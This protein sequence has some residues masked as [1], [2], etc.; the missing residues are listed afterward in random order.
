[1]GQTSTYVATSTF[2]QST[3]L[4]L[5]STRRTLTSRG[6]GSSWVAMAVI[7][8]IWLAAGRDNWMVVVTAIRLAGNW[9]VITTIRLAWDSTAIHRRCWATAVVTTITAILT[10]EVR[11]SWAW[12]WTTV[13]A[14]RGAVREWRERWERARRAG[15]DVWVA[16]VRC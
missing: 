7:T 9:L 14:G 4:C 12:A 11:R 10:T 2:S 16:A 8:T 3:F 5:N 13:M 1:M 6:L 15:G